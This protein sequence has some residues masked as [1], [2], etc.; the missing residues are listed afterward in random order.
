MQP[1][2][3]YRTPKGMVWQ[4]VGAGRGRLA[5][6]R[7]TKPKQAHPFRDRQEASLDYFVCSLRFAQC[8]MN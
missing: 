5:C 2:T 7:M 6:F 3:P 8:G 4:G 1:R